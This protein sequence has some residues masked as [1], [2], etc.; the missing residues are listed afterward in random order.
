MTLQIEFIEE[1]ARRT[2]I[3]EIQL[4]LFRSQVPTEIVFKP[5][6]EACLMFCEPISDDNDYLTKEKY[7]TIVAAANHVGDPKF[8][9]SQPHGSL[10]DDPLTRWVYV[11]PED[12]KTHQYKVESKEF[13]KYWWCA[14]P[15]PYDEYLYMASGGM[16]DTA[17]Y[18][19]DASWGLYT[20]HECWTLV[21]GSIPFIRHVDKMYP[22]W[23]KEVITLL[24]DYPP[25]TITRDM[26]TIK[27]L[28]ALLDYWKK[29]PA[30]EW[31]ETLSAKL[32]ARLTGGL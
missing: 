1:P 22:A 17:I 12:F 7:E 31:V 15:P 2:E 11:K 8:V 14:E 27:L 21:G 25:D 30:D 5:H 32:D 18:S 29:W 23:R 13:A 20:M 24:D 6:I 4:R 28:L 19:M 16:F 10:I 26:P 3:R 9:V